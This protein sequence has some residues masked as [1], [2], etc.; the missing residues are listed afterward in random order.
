MRGTW[1]LAFAVWGLMAAF[2]VPVHAVDTQSVDLTSGWMWT[3]NTVALPAI[4]VPAIPMPKV[5]IP[6][7]AISASDNQPTVVTVGKGAQAPF[8]KSV[9]T[10]SVG[11][12][13]N[14]IR[15]QSPIDTPPGARGPSEGGA[16]DV[17]KMIWRGL[18]AFS[19]QMCGGGGKPIIGP[20]CR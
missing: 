10:A 9:S 14:P 8:V 3:A 17:L 13:I 12:S 2:A 7:R 15:P 16:G 19:K 1:V 5:A 20:F 4:A 11:I 6:A 18:S